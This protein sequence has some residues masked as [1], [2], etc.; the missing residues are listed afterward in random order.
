MSRAAGELGYPGGER[1]YQLLKTRFYWQG[2][3]LDCITICQSLHPAQVE[4]QPFFRQPML[5]PTFKTRAPFNV[6]CLDLITKLEPPGAEG[7]TI[8]M[9]AVDPFSKFVLA[10]PLKS[11]SSGE[12]MRWLHHRIVCF[13]GVPLALRVD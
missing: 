1:L 8:C 5:S 9:V 6:W 12:T 2:M 13:F 3:R 10:D 4:N 11:K 7:E